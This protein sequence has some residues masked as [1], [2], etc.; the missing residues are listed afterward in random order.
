MK[1]KFHD[2]KICKRRQHTVNTTPALLFFPARPKAILAS[3]RQTRP[4]ASLVTKICSIVGWYCTPVDS[5]FSW[6][7]SSSLDELEPPEPPVRPSWRMI[8]PSSLCKAVKKNYESLLR[9]VKV[10][11]EVTDLALMNRSS[12]TGWH[13]I[14]RI[15]SWKRK[16]L[17]TDSFPPSIQ[18]KKTENHA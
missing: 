14:A 2:S 16:S 4:L 11:R 10:T 9:N 6:M 18:K 17:L 13:V 3:R 7:V 1:R 15:L 12:C 8:R 5:E